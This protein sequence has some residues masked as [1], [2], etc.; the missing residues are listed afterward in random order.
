MTH[1]LVRGV[2]FTKG[3]LNHAQM[4]HGFDF[5]ISWKHCDMIGLVVGKIYKSTRKHSCFHEIGGMWGCGFSAI[6][7]CK[8]PPVHSSKMTQ[9]LSCYPSGCGVGPKWKIENPMSENRET[10]KLIV[11]HPLPTQL[12]IE[13]VS[14]MCTCWLN[15]QKPGE[16]TPFF[17]I[18]PLKPHQIPTQSPTKSV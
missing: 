3:C 9:C 16:K 17:L 2:T 6:L 7:T 4:V 13:W 15:T 1:P 12:V 14:P 18:S 5:Q 8:L 11:G 10:Q